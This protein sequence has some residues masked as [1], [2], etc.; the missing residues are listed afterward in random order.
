MGDKKNMDWTDYMDKSDAELMGM[1]D[2]DELEEIKRRKMITYMYYRIMYQKREQEL[3]EMWDSIEAYHAELVEKYGRKAVERLEEDAVQ[4]KRDI[5]K[6]EKCEE[7]TRHLFDKEKLGECG[8]RIEKLSKELK[9]KKEDVNAVGLAVLTS[10]E[11]AEPI[12][13]RI[14][15]AENPMDDPEIDK[16]R[17]AS[18]E[19]MEN[20]LQLY[21][22]GN[23]EPLAMMMKAGLLKCCQ[24]YADCKDKTEAVKWSGVI[25]DILDDLEKKPELLDICG[26]SQQELDTARGAVVMGEIIKKGQKALAEYQDAA[27]S[28]KPL[29]RNQEE[30]YSLSIIQM[31][32]VFA[33]R[34]HHMEAMQGVTEKLPPSTLQ[35]HIGRN[36][37]VEN[38][39]NG[40]L[41]D[42]NENLKTQIKKTDVF[43][44]IQ[45]TDIFTR[46]SVFSRNEDRRTVYRE[47]IR[48]LEVRYA[49]ESKKNVQQKEAKPE[50]KQN[51]PAVKPVPAPKHPLQEIK[52][53]KKGPSIK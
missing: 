2:G 45:N 39:R 50:I 11:N 24:N 44:K 6:T 12:V 5:A 20:L 27:L 23:K 21:K 38:A 40:R 18:A 41:A 28:G 19:T 4:T 8:E 7:Y 31:E 15:K 9:L 33:D 32:M 30:E 14:I 42:E 25:G 43:K 35:N 16:Y 22:E 46:A 47:T 51:Q 37:T 3:K 36:V 52:T 29:T 49:E 10:D 17:I 13:D 1:L 53:D 34:E 26:F 48:E